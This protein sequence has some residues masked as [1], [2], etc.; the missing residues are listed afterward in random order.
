MSV[1]LWRFSGDE[2]GKIKAMNGGPHRGSRFPENMLP[3]YTV[4]KGKDKET[5]GGNPDHTDSYLQW[6]TDGEDMYYLFDLVHTD[7]PL[8]EE[9]G[10][11]G[12]DSIMEMC[13]VDMNDLFD[14]LHSYDFDHYKRFIFPTEQH[15]VFDVKYTGGSGYGPDG[16]DDWDIDV[17][18]IGY[19][20]SQMTLKSFNK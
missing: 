10:M 8:N 16:N 17:Q 9:I 7:N 1:V 11:G 20:D 3:E 12:L 14:K 4:R 19:L 5:G 18:L 13:K 15:I 6:I 2:I